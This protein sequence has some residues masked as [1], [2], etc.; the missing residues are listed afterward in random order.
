MRSIGLLFRRLFLFA[1]KLVLVAIPAV[2]ASFYSYR[3][4]MRDAVTNE[5]AIVAVMSRLADVLD[6]QGRDLEEMRGEVNVLKML[7]ASRQLPLSP[8]E[9]LTVPLQQ[10]NQ[11]VGG[12]RILIQAVPVNTKAA[13][14]P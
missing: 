9:R 7:A 6:R 2:V 11:N 10:S 3:C 13:F 4:A 5:R 8:A 12:P 14:A 1:V